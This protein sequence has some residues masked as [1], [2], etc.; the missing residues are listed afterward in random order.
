MFDSQYDVLPG[1]VVTTSGLGLYPEGIVIGKVEKVIEDK[2]NSLK[3]VVVKPNVDFKNIDDVM[4]IEVVPDSYSHLFH[5]YFD[6]M[7]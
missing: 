7:L 3:Y 2:N 5:P 1:D 4:I 6:H